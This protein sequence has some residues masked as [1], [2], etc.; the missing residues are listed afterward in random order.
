MRT[1][2]K[3][4]ILALLL[5][6]SP[7]CFALRSL[8]IV[9][10]AEAKALGIQVRTVSASNDVRVM[11]E[12]KTDGKFAAFSYVELEIKKDGKRQVA[13]Q[14]RVDRPTPESATTYFITDR[15]NLDDST[16]T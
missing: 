8:V 3:L 16:L 11:L 5:L 9:T 14:L 2:F 10:P 12:F 1:T 7:R 15:A 13:T 6:V 4:A